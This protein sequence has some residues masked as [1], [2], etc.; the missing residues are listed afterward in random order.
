MPRRRIEEHHSWPME[1]KQTSVILVCTRSSS[2]GPQHGSA[3]AP[4]LE[5]DGTART[6]AAVSKKSEQE[7]NREDKEGDTVQFQ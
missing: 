4:A 7:K 3:P 5:E 1:R 6:S 2:P